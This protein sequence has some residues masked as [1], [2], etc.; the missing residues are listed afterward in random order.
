MPD[1]SKT[2][3]QL[4]ELFGDNVTG[5]ISPQDGRDLVESIF[6][7][8]GITLLHSMGPGTPQSI[9]TSFVKIDQ[10][11]SDE[12]S[13][14]G[15]TTDHAND[16]ITVIK[17]GVFIFSASLSVG[18]DPN[19]IWQGTLFNNNIDAD[20]AGIDVLIGGGSDIV[21]AS[22]KDII[23]LADGDELDYRMKANSA[24]K[25]FELHSGSLLLFR[26]G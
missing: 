19:V 2:L 14:S 20:S 4:K 22:A 11:T 1:I 21:R 8:G 24:A 3:A 12:P 15:V 25:S 5:D 7:Y 13:S 9:G 6:Q 26:V 17:G 23:T 16:K 18:G 10:F